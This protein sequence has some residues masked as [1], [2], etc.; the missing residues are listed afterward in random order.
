MLKKSL[1]A[2][3]LLFAVASSAFA[4]QSQMPPQQQGQRQSPFERLDRNDDG[5]ITREEVTIARTAT[6]TRMDANRDGFISREESLN[7]PQRTRGPD[8]QS[9]YSG[10]RY[11]GGGINLQSG[12]ANRDGILTRA[13]FDAAF[14]NSPEHTTAFQEQLRNGMFTNLDTNRDGSISSAEMTAAPRLPRRVT[15]SEPYLAEGPPPPM[16]QGG[17]A[18]NRRFNADTNNDQR[19]SLAEWLARPD[20]LF[21]RGD[22][23]K[24]GRLTREE[25]AAFTRQAREQGQR[26][27][28]GRR[29]PW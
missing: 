5:V 8:G 16:Q 28:D 9:V 11:N 1:L 21:D 3:T 19:I 20:P 10:P 15:T 13:E 22:T 27:K 4:Q 29:R 18:N 7:Q 6:F 24:D 2:A 26:P 12:D 17:P 23:N 25:A 14:T